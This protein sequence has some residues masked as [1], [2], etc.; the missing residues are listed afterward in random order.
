MYY[1]LRFMYVTTSTKQEALTIGRTLVEEKLA[2]CVNI[3]EGMESIYI[4]NNTLEH[5][6]ECVL[7]A[8]THISRVKALTNRVKELHSYDCPCVTSITV[9]EDEGN[10]DYLD[11]LLKGS[12]A[13]S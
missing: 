1:N 5:S 7:I 2:T 6:K 12:K 3:L 11:W 13:E 10:K 9:T 4:W 8:K